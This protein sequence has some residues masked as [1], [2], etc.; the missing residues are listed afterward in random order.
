MTDRSEIGKANNRNGRAAQD[1]IFA[2]LGIQV[3]HRGR[4]GNE[5]TWSESPFVPGLR[6]EVKSGRMPVFI[7]K[8]ITQAEGL[9]GFGSTFRGAVAIVDD[10]MPEPYALVPLRQL[11][12]TCRDLAEL[13][14]G[15][16]VKSLVRDAQRILDDIKECAS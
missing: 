2:T 1:L 8:A 12:D 7:R 16:R 13:G 10:T 14:Q 15:A 9:R 11:V 5:E 3:K 4:K 6:W